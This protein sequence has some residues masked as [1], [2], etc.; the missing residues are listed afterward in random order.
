MQIMMKTILFIDDNTEMLENTAELLELSNYKVYTASNGRDGVKLAQKEK[1][2]LIICDV[3][4][5]GLDGYEVLHILSQNENTQRIPFIFLTAKSAKT[6]FR[7]GMNLGADDYLT[8]PFEEMDLLRTIEHKLKKFEARNSMV[9]DT[10]EITVDDLLAQA[11]VKIFKAKEKIFYESESPSFVFYILEGEVKSW[12]ID[13]YGKE[14]ITNIYR[15]GEFIGY[16]AVIDE[17]SYK[18][19]AS[20]LME[21]KLAAIPK[22]KFLEWIKNNHSASEVFLKKMANTIVSTNE[23]LLKVSY[24]SLRE[25]V[26][27]S[28]L[29]IAKSSEFNEEMLTIEYSREDLSNVVGTATESLIRVLKEFKDDKLINVDK[30][31]IEIIDKAGL[32]KLALN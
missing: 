1:P 32:E 18:H 13:A 24:G 25:R 17:T 8:K 9:N 20:T 23:K 29:K 3:M 19:S 12:K 14:L 16:T 10:K 15:H 21:T 4:M 22:S 28:L 2:D 30:R 5:P 31:K 11:N 26:A 7:K 27:Q 6:D